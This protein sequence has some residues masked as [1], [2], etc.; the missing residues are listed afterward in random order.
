LRLIKSTV[1]ELKS[2]LPTFLRTL[3]MLTVI[4]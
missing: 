4:T 2:I 3:L 1:L